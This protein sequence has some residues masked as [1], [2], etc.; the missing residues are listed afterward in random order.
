[1]TQNT[2][3]SF[4]TTI[5]RPRNCWLSWAFPPGQENNVMRASYF[6][7][8]Y[9][10]K[11]Q[12]LVNQ[13]MLIAWFGVCKFMRKKLYMCKSKSS[14]LRVLWIVRSVL[15]IYLLVCLFVIRLPVRLCVWPSS[16]STVIML[17]VATS[18]SVT[19]VQSPVN[20]PILRWT[21]ASWRTWCSSWCLVLSWCLLEPGAT[22][23]WPSATGKAH[24]PLSILTHYCCQVLIQF[25]LICFTHEVVC[26]CNTQFNLILI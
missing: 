2:P 3:Q 23:T 16:L 17:P 15:F 5:W 19:A 26:V 24:T 20:W 4:V 7:K 13:L 1:M 14:A 25:T 12:T 22:R 18:W 21:P 8:S 11:C 10:S 6:A 9:Y